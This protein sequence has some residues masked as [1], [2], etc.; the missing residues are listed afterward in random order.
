MKPA[1]PLDAGRSEVKNGGRFQGTDEGRQF[2]RIDLPADQVDQCRTA[3][4]AA[5]AMGQCFADMA[6][7]GDPEAEHWRR[8]TCRGQALKQPAMVECQR[9]MRSPSTAWYQA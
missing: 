5:R 1:A 6:G 9:I 8:R 3:D 2:R 4:D 7:I